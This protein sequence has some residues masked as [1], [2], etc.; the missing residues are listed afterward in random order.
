M[1]PVISSSALA[2]RILLLGGSTEASALAR[3]LAAD[4]RFATTLS[5]AGRTA[6]PRAQP[7]ATRN[8]GFGGVEGLVRYLQDERIDALVDATHPFAAQM[9]RN[10]IEAAAA[11]GTPLLAVERPAWQPQ[12]GD[13]WTLAPDMAAAV[14]AIGPAQRK[15]FSGIG[16]LALAELQAAPQH[17]YVIRLIDLPKGPLDLPNI[18]FIQARG[19]FTA[20]DDLRLFRE[21]GIEVVLA[22][23]SGGDA[24]VS[25]IEAA[26]ALGLPVMMVRRPLIPPRP[27]VATAEDAMVWLAQH[28]SGR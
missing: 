26:R 19:P 12:P 1:E 14:Q 20:E 4:G 9:S 24:T 25:K 28:D 17:I 13:N 6:A 10:A 23:N 8:G 22:K 5:F 18:V 7:V 3:L 16:S 2:M 27:T 11:T 15:V 21:H